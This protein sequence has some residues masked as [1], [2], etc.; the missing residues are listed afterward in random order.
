MNNSRLLDFIPPEMINNL[1][2]QQAA[3]NPP[4]RPTQTTIEKEQTFP[5]SNLATSTGGLLSTPPQKM[6]RK[7]VD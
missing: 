7:F 4:P 1:K 2:M 5:K 6:A 3:N